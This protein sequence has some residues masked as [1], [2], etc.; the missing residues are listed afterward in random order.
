MALGAH[1]LSALAPSGVSNEV[2][3]RAQMK[4]TVECEYLVGAGPEGLGP[5]RQVSITLKKICIT[6]PLQCKQK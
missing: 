5:L 4:T 2:A 1:Q 3:A 6:E